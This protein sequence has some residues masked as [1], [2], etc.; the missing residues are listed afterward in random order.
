MTFDTIFFDCDSTLISIE[1][2][3]ELGKALGVGEEVRKFTELSMDGT[4]PIEEVFKKKMDLM[5]PTREDVAAIAELC[6]RMFVP[7]AREVVE[8]LQRA[9]KRVFL[10]S[11]NFHAIVDSVARV[12]GISEDRII[13]NDIYF[14]ADGKYAGINEASPLCSQNGKG[15][16]VRHFL[17]EGEKSAFVGDGMTDAST[18]GVV[19]MFIGFGGVAVR[20]KVRERADVYISEPHLLSLLPL[21]L[22]L[23]K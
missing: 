23:E 17:N 19:D 7:G 3:Y 20:E 18:Q 15:E 16:I 4:T 11:S 22:G 9:G 14:D 8:E 6:T 12:L 13:A 10:V 1:S 5:A 2:L 21:L